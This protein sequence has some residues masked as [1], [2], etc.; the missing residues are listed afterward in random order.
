MTDDLDRVMMVMETAFEP[1][2]GEAWTRPQ[3]ADALAMP[4]TFYL[5]AGIDGAAPGANGEAAGFTLSR[6]AADEEELLLLA[7]APK[8]RQRGIGTKLLSRYIEQA[9]SR[10]ALKLFLEMRDG[11]SAQGLYSRLGFVPVGRR[12]GYYR[13]IDGRAIDAITFALAS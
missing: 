11:N 3:V 6:G 10:G 1:T 2:Y 7:V 8:Y 12:C 5:L 4:N 9:H 13:A